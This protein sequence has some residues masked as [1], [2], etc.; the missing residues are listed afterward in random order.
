MAGGYVMNKFDRAEKI[1]EVVRAVAGCSL[2]E[3]VDVIIATLAFITAREN[4][5]KMEIDNI[6]NMYSQ[7][8]R[9]EIETSRKLF[10]FEEIVNARKSKTRP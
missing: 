5:G 6:V 10:N 1:G 4:W 3:G 8:L 2:G 9:E 7:R